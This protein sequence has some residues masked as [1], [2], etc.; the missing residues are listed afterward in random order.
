MSMYGNNVFINIESDAPWEWR[1][2]HP[3]EWLILGVADA[4]GVGIGFGM[5]HHYLRS[6]FSITK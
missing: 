1:P 6:A 5:W 3:W 4:N 2:L